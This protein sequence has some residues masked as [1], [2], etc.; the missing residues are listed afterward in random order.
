MM[1]SMYR[2]VWDKRGAVAHARAV[3]EAIASGRWKDQIKA[4][5]K[6]SG[7]HKDE[8]KKRLPAVT[9]S[10]VFEKRRGGIKCLHGYT[11]VL[12]ADVDHRVN[13]LVADIAARDEHCLFQFRSPSGGLKMG[14]L[15]DCPA[16]DHKTAGFETVKNHVMSHYK[17]EIDKACK[18]INRLCFIS[19]DPMATWND[20]A[21]P[22][23]VPQMEKTIRRR[24][25]GGSQHKGDPIHAA[26]MFANKFVGAYVKGQRNQWLYAF[27]SSCNKR[28]V[29]QEACLAEVAGLD[30]PQSEI[31]A[32]VKSAYANTSEFDTLGTGSS[33]D[34]E[35]RMLRRHFAGRN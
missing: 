8:L 1:V 5:R 21:T 13:N 15:L 27:C 23:Y 22:M 16:E 17:L 24:R 19:W 6:S 10:G 33:Y 14:F 30:L 25:V 31:E 11:G 18:D 34:A 12:V 29:P 32:T 2:D 9:F 3:V 4:I 26:R 7:A 28:G 35:E 20:H